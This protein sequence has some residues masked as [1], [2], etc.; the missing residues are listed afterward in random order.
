M[1]R[2]EVAAGGGAML[3]PMSRST[4]P[5]VG[6]TGAERDAADRRRAEIAARHLRAWP[7][8][9]PRRPAACT[10]WR[11]SAMTSSGP[12]GFYQAAP[13]VPA[14]RDVREPRLPRLD[15]LLLRHRQRQPAWRSSTSPGSTS[16]VRRGARRA[17]TTSR[18]PWS[19]SGGSTSREARRGRRPVRRRSAGC[20]LYFRD[21]DGARLE[22]ISDP[23]GEMYGSAVI[24]LP[25]AARGQAQKRS[26]GGRGESLSSIIARTWPGNGLA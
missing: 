2:R 8:A 21:P 10:T 4:E 3:G 25:G 13:R 16:P 17:S 1:T 26:N 22:L 19:P 12:S 9:L 24:D 6:L 23:L 11:S 5:T 18:S 14:D 20:R 7:N 15:T